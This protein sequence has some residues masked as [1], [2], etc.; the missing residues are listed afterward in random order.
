MA[1][2]N[3]ENKLDNCS[4]NFE[5]EKKVDEFIEKN[6][7]NSES[8]IIIKYFGKNMNKITNRYKQEVEEHNKNKKIKRNYAGF[9]YSILF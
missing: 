6:L 9:L 2:K 4:I 7:Y 3:L 5:N 8:V 1:E